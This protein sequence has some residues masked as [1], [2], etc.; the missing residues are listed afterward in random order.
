[1]DEWRVSDE[2][3]QGVDRGIN[4]MKSKEQKDD[5]ADLKAE[6]AK[7]KLVSD[8]ELAAAWKARRTGGGESCRDIARRLHSERAPLAKWVDT[9]RRAGRRREPMDTA[10]QCVAVVARYAGWAASQAR[11]GWRLSV[12]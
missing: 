12:E 8:D 3:L 6:V 4:E 10:A 2:R 1:M 5:K 9:L 7:M 11:D